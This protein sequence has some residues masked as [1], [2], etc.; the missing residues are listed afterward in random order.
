MPTI[1]SYQS[2]FDQIQTPAVNIIPDLNNVNQQINQLQASA[3][4]N[5]FGSLTGAHTKFH[6][7]IIGFIVPDVPIIYRAIVQLQTEIAQ[8][9]G[10]KGGSQVNGVQVPGNKPGKQP[11]QKTSFDQSDMRSLIAQNYQSITGRP[12]TETQMALFVAQMTVECGQNASAQTWTCNNFNLGNVHAGGQSGT[13]VVLTGGAQ[14]RG[15]SVPGKPPNGGSYY[16]GF[17]WNPVSGQ[18]ANGPNGVRSWYPTYYKSYDSLENAVTGHMADLA[19]NWPSTFT[20]GTPEEY[21]NALLNGVKGPYYTMPVGDYLGGIQKGYAATFNHPPIIPLDAVDVSSAPNASNNQIPPVMNLGDVTG[22]GTNTDDTRL[23]RDISPSDARQEIAQKQIN[24]LIQQI[25]AF[26]NTPPL[27]ML[28][29]PRSVNRSYERTVDSGTKGRQGPIVN[30]WTERP[31]V[32]S[33]R[34]VTAAHYALNGSGQGGLTQSNRIYSLSYLN[35]LSLV[36]LYRNNAVIFSGN[37]AA[38]SGSLGVPIGTMSLYIYYDEKMYIGSFDSFSVEDTV[39]NPY[40]F[41]YTFD[42]TV[43]Y[44]IDTKQVNEL[45]IRAT[46]AR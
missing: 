16:A 37:D 39:D 32:F 5:A 42:F 21:N 34:G 36:R 3:G 25:G 14:P 1:N 23:G 35:L 45:N 12:I 22:S 29:N 41:P 7:M 2:I 6:P 38:D 4:Q 28:I 46:V 31:G 13:P 43:R 26:R 24:S 40:N 11:Q 10:G 27:L 9:K 15:P 33:S 20:A 17:D 19:K 8:V 18:P 30:M 44:E